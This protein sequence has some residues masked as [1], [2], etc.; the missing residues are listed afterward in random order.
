MSLEFRGLGCG[1]FGILGE[2]RGTW[3]IRGCRALYFGVFG[4]WALRSIAACQPLVDLFRA[5]GVSV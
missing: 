5:S 4:A 2:V 1:A 3:A